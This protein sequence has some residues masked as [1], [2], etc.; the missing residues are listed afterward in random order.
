MAVYTDCP[1]IQL[2]TGNF[3]DEHGKNGIYYGKR[4]GVAL[5]T[6][7]YPDALHHADWPQPVT[8]A[9]NHYRS[10]TIYSFPDLSI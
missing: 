10:E 5:E 1:G 7:F 8:K 9:G 2:Y 4:S 3:L 6:Q